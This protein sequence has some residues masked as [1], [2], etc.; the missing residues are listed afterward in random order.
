MLQKKIQAAREWIRA[1]SLTFYIET[2][3]CQMNAH[4]SEKIAGVLADMGY[5][6]AE[7][8]YSADLV[9]FNTCCVRENAENKIYGNVGKMKKIKQKHKDRIVGV[10]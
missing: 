7:D 9:L 2:Y 4:D 3:G 6:P 8:K 5:A 10:C 1:H